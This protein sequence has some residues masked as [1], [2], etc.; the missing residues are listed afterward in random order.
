VM[1]GARRS[2]TLASAGKYAMD[3]WTAEVESAVVRVLPGTP[4]AGLVDPRGLAQAVAAGFVGL[5][6]Y[7][8]VDPE[9]AAGA[10]G[11]LEAIGALV[12]AFEGLPPM[13]V[14]AVRSRARKAVARAT[15]A[16]AGAG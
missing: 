1:A 11:S 12:A 5:E 9:A 15:A 14:R 3:R 2:P 10:L 8:G 6:L 16:H 4:L 13:A 7:D